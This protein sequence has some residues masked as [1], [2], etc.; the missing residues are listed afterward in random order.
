MHPISK[1]AALAIFAATAVVA[2]GVGRVT[3]PAQTA[4]RPADLAGAIR[5]SLG[6]GDAVRRLAATT[7]LLERLERKDLPDVLAVY[8]GMMPAIDAWDLGAFFG[9]WARFDPAG[10]IEYALALPRRNMLEE[11]RIGVRAALAGWAYADPAKA[12]V[13]AEKV[14][15]HNAPL[16]VDVWNGLVTGWVRSGRDL[17]GLV[18]F[19]DELRPRT[20][21][22]KSA[23]VAV[24]ELVRVA[25]ADAALAWADAILGDESQEQS[26]KR[27][28]FEAALR[29]SGALD[30]ARTG[31]WVLGY[32][33]AE[34]APDGAVITGRRWGRVDGTAA[35]AWLEKLPAGQPRDRGVREAFLAW[36]TADWDGAQAWLESASL[37]AFHDPALE[38]LA[39]QLLAWDPAEAL[40]WCERIL[41][42]M[43]R[44]RCLSS[45]ASRWYAKDALAAEAWLQ[46]SSLDEEAR[47]EVRKSTGTGQAGP[48]KRR[49]R[50]GAGQG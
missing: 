4:G 22:D 14:A 21:R 36:A 39:E 10:A 16:R 44:A 47:S 9:A 32:A 42:E 31:A 49:R 50:P 48:A 43:P 2:F 28:V 34:Y 6:E 13:A 15:K 1:G 38:V 27:A 3:A 7:A 29:N 46:T 41:G 24:R 11:R 37:T 26:L 17:E 30:P 20:Q 12:R 40:G 23:E 25:G 33:E 5:A 45:G 8:E 19:L 18:G 35:M